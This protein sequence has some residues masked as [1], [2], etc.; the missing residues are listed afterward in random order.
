VNL[1]ADV[2]PPLPLIPYL[3]TSLHF[4]LLLLSSFSAVLLLP[5]PFATIASTPK[6]EDVEKNLV[7]KVRME[8]KE[9]K[10]KQFRMVRQTGFT[11]CCISS[12]GV[13]GT[14]DLIRTVAIT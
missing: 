1:I 10:E 9:K 8:E 7:P 11:R 5:S 4:I 14:L 6:M 12:N 2:I 3:F 13:I